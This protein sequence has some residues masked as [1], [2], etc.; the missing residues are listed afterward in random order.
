[1]S[2]QT[3]Q[4]RIVG[5]GE[6]DPATLTPHPGNWRIHPGAQRAAM[7]GVLGELGWLQGVMVNQRTG[8]VVDGHLRLDLAQR[9]GASTIPV[10]YVDLSPEEEAR[11]LATL[12]PLGALAGL[13]Q[14]RMKALAEQQATVNASLRALIGTTEGAPDPDSI[15]QPTGMTTDHTALIVEEE[16]SD[17]LAYDPF[18][19]ENDYAATSIRLVTFIM[20]VETYEDV[21]GRL[22]AIG[23]RQDTETNADT[24]LWLLETYQP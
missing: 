8:L 17:G 24:I 12:N 13:D 3:W 11:V 4:N 23:E 19:A 20:D 16:A 1:M 21:L 7:T 22:D 2:D 5:Y 10:T 14:D 18:D 6:A 15:K 9:A